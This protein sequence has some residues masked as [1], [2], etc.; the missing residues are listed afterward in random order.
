MVESMLL[1]HGI[2]ENKQR[3]KRTLSYVTKSHAF[4]SLIAKKRMSFQTDFFFDL[5]DPV[6]TS[7]FR[8]DGPDPSEDDSH[9][10]YFWKEMTT[11]I[12]SAVQAGRTI[13][14]QLHWSKSGH[15]LKLDNGISAGVEP[16]FCTTECT[17]GESLVPSYERPKLPQSKYDVT[18]AFAQKK[19]FLDSDQMDIIDY[20]ERLLCIQRGRRRAYTA[21]V[22]C[23]RGEQV[24]RWA[25][26]TEVDGQFVSKVTKPASL[27]PGCEGQRQLL[28]M[29]SKSSRELG[30]DFPT[31]DE[32][33]DGKLLKVLCLVGEGATAKVY[34]A[35]WGGDN[36]VIKVFK[37][38]LQ[39]IA[40]HEKAVSDRLVESKVAG[41]LKCTKV[42][43][44]V[45]FFDQLLRPFLGTLSV[46]NVASI[47]DFLKTVH[48]AGV[49]H[50]DIRPENIMQDA[51]GNLYL[52]D[53]GFALL[54]PDAD[55]YEFAGTFRYG[56][57]AAVSAALEE[58]MYHYSSR[59]DLESF[60]KTVMAV[61]SGGHRIPK[62]QL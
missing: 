3:P 56:S 45:L 54:S 53:W 35:S 1:I 24:I 43:N 31:F 37:D 55:G 52:I 48:T 47:L 22:H 50:R 49:F 15:W 46:G 41:I 6:E 38:G 51:N 34:S 11:L 14:Q 10:C 9:H 27:L 58:R 20:G 28:T 23:A 2:L 7:A 33:V 39:H 40:D 26:T 32:P 36:G 18:I 60:V 57:E 16:D 13:H 59:D 29:L 62:R 44:G 19:E 8:S 42:S 25:E 4:S 17:H 61:N 12:E 21:L 30:R 5:V